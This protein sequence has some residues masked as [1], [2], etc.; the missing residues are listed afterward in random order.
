MS[1]YQ[2]KYSN[3]NSYSF[4]NKYNPCSKLNIQT[5]NFN[6]KNNKQNLLRSYCKCLCHPY[7]TYCS[8]CCNNCCYEMYNKTC[9]DLYCLQKENENKNCFIN[10]LQRENDILKSNEKYQNENY[11]KLFKENYQLKVDNIKKDKMIDKSLRVLNIYGENNNNENMKIKGDINYYLENPLEFNEMIDSQTNYATMNEYNKKLQNSSL[12]NNNFNYNNNFNNNNNSY[13]LMNNNSDNLNENNFNYNNNMPNNDD[14]YK[15]NLINNK[16]KSTPPNIQN[17]EI[18]KQI[19][20]NNI[21]D[22]INNNNVNKY[23]YFPPFLKD[24]NIINNDENK[25]VSKG[26][27]KKKLKSK[28]KTKLKRPKSAAKKVVKKKVEPT[29]K[30]KT[31]KSKSKKKVLKRPKTANSVSK[32][33]VKKKVKKTDNNNNNNSEIRTIKKTTVKKTKK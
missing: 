21:N 13:P 14:D 8:N 2:S 19:F 27:K 29:E 33:V 6:Y 32:K 30:T 4:D 5:Y 16:F 25:I 28:S 22:D 24:K 10:E 31:I 18:K 23:D 12:D 3:L 1:F 15:N 9:N 26:I 20:N 17:E 7:K 11:S